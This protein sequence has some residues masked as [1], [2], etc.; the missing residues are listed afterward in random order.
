MESW[1]EFD[2]RSVR[3]IA[4][5]GKIRLDQAVGWPCGTATVCEVWYGKA[6]V[7]LTAL[8]TCIVLTPSLMP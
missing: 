5:V 1:G 6:V 8:L 3:R 4:R 2:I 7:G